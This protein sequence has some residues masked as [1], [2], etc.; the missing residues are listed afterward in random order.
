MAKPNYRYRVNI[1]IQ[2]KGADGKLYFQPHH[3]GIWDSVTV[4]R[5]VLAGL[6][7]RGLA[8]HYRHRDGHMPTGT[9]NVVLAKLTYHGD[10]LK[11]QET[12]SQEWF[13]YGVSNDYTKEYE[14]GGV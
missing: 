14:V 5:G 4:A 3:V 1:E 8:F 2:V 12:L 6:D 9:A 11:G 13:N 7:H 10:A